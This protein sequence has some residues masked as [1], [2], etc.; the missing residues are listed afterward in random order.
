MEA[1]FKSV[2]MQELEEAFA[3]AVA[4]LTGSETKVA[5]RMM[6]DVSDGGD[7]LIGQERWKLGVVVTV[8]TPE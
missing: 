4:T 7:H 1:P 8:A 2:T 3:I 5:I 6:E